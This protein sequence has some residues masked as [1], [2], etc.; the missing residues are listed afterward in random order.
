MK[1]SILIIAL[2]LAAVAQG[3]QRDR[4]VDL[5]VRCANHVG[6]SSSGSVW[7]VTRCGEVYNAD[8]IGTSWHLHSAKAEGAFNNEPTMD[9]VAPFGGHTAVVAGFLPDE[10]VHSYNFVMRTTD[11]GHTWDTVQFGRGMHWIDGFCYHSD[12]RLWMGSNNGI[13]TFS[14]DSGRTFT[15]LRDSAFEIKLGIDDIYMLT[16]DSGWIAGHGNRIY[17]THDNWHTWRRWSTPL[18]Q[19]LYKVTN[20]HNQYWV[21]RVRPW[22]GSLLAV[23][24]GMSFITPLGDSL[25]WQPTGQ[26]LVD[27]E[28]DTVTGNLWAINDSG[29]LLYIESLE[30]QR[31]VRERLLSL[32]RICGIIGGRVYLNT[33]SGVVRIAPDGRADTCGLF[34]EDKTIEDVFAETIAELGEYANLYLP[35]I[36][37]HGGCLWR[38]DGKSIYLQDAIG[39]YRIAKPL[40]IREMNPDPDREDRV[41]IL[42]GDGRNY[43]VDTA[44]HIEPYTYSQPLARFL[45]SGLQ[46][47]KIQT[48]ESGCFHY[49]R[50]IVSYTRE[51]NLLRETENT[52]DSTPHTPL[53]FPAEALEQTMRHLD[54]VCSLF[55]TPA[56]FGLQEGDV[57]LQKVFGNRYGWCTSSS[58]Y[59]LTFVNGKGSTLNVFGSS[60]DDC[61]EYFPWMLPMTFVSDEES[62]VSY[63]PLLWQA[64]RPMMPE[65]MMNRRFL[66]NNSLYDLRPCDLLFFPDTAATGEYT[67]VALVESVDDTVWIIDA[68]PQNGVSRRP[69]L[70]TEYDGDLLPDVYRFEHTYFYFDSVLARARAFIGQPYDNDFLP[71]NGALYDSELIYECYL[72]DVNEDKTDRHLLE[73]TPMHRRNKNVMG[74]TP[75][76]LS[77]SKRLREL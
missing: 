46:S 1:K 75:T 48:G 59:T 5:N 11:G 36:I 51:G 22:R 7:M 20:P 45:E 41:I 8:S 23:Q 77:Q 30:R 70:R 63:Q 68:T 2:L 29:Q 60:N 44:G 10:D 56:D 53:T 13:L 37:S 66:N 43:S 71:D 47:V 54:E 14:A 31:V 49:E 73:A 42:R 18:D 17:S 76:S 74:T 26:P 50:H 3:Q 64:L 58:G 40:G 52:V 32:E 72:D 38:H 12:G 28:V 15:V 34:T 16:A 67:H 69:F 62:F 35:T 65:G 55:P 39:W 6:I 19:G 25:Q 33:A 4:R 9:R 21:T 24:A 61:G 27:F 57:D